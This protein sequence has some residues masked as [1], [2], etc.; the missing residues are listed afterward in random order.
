MSR[1]RTRCMNS[2]G[3]GPHRSSRESVRSAY[4]AC[5]VFR[6]GENLTPSPPNCLQVRDLREWRRGWDSFPTNRQ[7]S[8]IEAGSE[9]PE[10]ARSTRNLSIR[11]KTGT[12]QSAPASNARIRPIPGAPATPL[13]RG[14]RQSAPRR[15]SSESRMQVR[16]PNISDTPRAHGPSSVASPLDRRSVAPRPAR[17]PAVADSVPTW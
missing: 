5:Q 11:Y 10:T 14:H 1:E 13:A 12:A 2:I 7:P 15:R 6:G 4:H 8:T 9:P 16:W 17:A 3:P